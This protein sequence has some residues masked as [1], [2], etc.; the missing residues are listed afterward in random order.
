MTNQHPG[1]DHGRVPRVH[2]LMTV[3]DRKA[4]TLASLESVAA[5]RADAGAEIS[6]VL[7]DDGCSDGTPA[8]VRERYP[9]VV[10]VAGSGQLYWNGGMRRAFEVAREDDPDHYL[11]LNDDTN[12]LPGALRTLLATHQDRTRAEGR[13]CIVVG[14]T[15]DPVTGKHSYGGWRRGGP[16]N[17]A[18]LSRIAPG[19][20]A[21]A[22]DTLHGNCVLIPRDVVHRIGILD[23]AFTHAMG[24][25]DYGFR[26]ARAGVGLWIA[27]GYLG[28]CAENT[29]RGLFTD[30]TLG[31]REQWRRILGPKGLPPSEWLVF[32]RRHCG[33]LW[34]LNFCWPYLK[35]WWSAARR[36]WSRREGL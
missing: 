6:V 29:G 24:D 11:M 32:T 20:E 30:A 4:K 35:I 17:P 25:L 16:L 5:Q 18:R 27:P 15:V 34:P 13:P 1:A 8:A 21:R 28:E 12:L 23:V 19:P 36:A 2:V 10:V 26:A 14:S 22:C 9:E 3:H 31:V 7:V 33:P